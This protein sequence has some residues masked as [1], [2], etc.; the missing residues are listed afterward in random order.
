VQDQQ[1]SLA[2]V[3]VN[4]L[5]IHFEAASFVNRCGQGPWNFCFMIE[6]HNPEI[7]FWALLHKNTRK[8]KG[9]QEVHAIATRI[10]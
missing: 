10:K 3:L 5:L 9:L 4:A 1:C 6:G 7:E 2:W 8:P